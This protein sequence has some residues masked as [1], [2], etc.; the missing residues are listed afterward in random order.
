MDKGGARPADPALAK[1]EPVA[2]L[3]PSGVDPSRVAA[4]L[5]AAQRKAMIAI[6][7]P[8]GRI[9]WTTDR[10][11]LRMITVNGVRIARVTQDTLIDLGLV[12]AKK[13]MIGYLPK[14]KAVR[15]AIAMDTRSG[16]T[17]R[18]GPK[19][20]SAGPTGIAR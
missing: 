9:R 4:R 1:A 5:T 16:E 6:D 17:E 13:G 2:R 18:L 11:D 8:Y 15:A 3:G 19:G 14:G 12:W 20:D 7:R 10:W